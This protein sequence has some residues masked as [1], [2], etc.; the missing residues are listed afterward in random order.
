[1][2]VVWSCYESP[3]RP[4]RLVSL[5]LPQG[6]VVPPIVQAE[7]DAEAGFVRRRSSTL[8]TTEITWGNGKIRC[9]T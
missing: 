6:V 7:D 3:R 5:R 1:M 9:P 4:Q 2:G 8:R